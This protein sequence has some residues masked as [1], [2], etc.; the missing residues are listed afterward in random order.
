MGHARPRRRPAAHEA[1]KR[2]RARR[3]R[4][5]AVRPR[6]CSTIRC[7]GC[8]GLERRPR[9]RRAARPTRDP[10]AQRRRA[11]S[12]RPRGVHR[13]ADQAGA[14]LAPVRR[15]SPRRWPA[16]RA[17]APEPRVPSAAPAPARGA[18]ILLAEDNPINQA[19]AL[20]ILEPP[21]LPRRRRRQRR[22]RRSTRCAASTYAAVLMD[23]QMP[24]LDGYA[25]TAEIR[26]P[27]GRRAAHA[28][29]RHDRERDAGRPRAL[30]RRGMDDYL[31]KPLD[32]AALDAVL[33]RWVG[34]TEATV[35]DR[36]VL[37]ALARDVGDEAIVDEICD[38]F[39]TETGPRLD[40]IERAA[41]GPRRR[42]C[43]ASAP[44]RSRA[45]PPMLARSRS[46]AR[47]P[48][49]SGWREAGELGD[50]RRRCCG[51]PTRWN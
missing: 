51:W 17:G 15:R 26:A 20:D 21:R 11:T 14:R 44:T 32:G 6:R 30:P 29:H 38:L 3:G 50:C 33:Q 25:A 4:R 16:R 8:D 47:R 27:R 1:L 31:S 19:V 43:C 12:R 9:D 48:S 45:R 18:S 5:A 35:M 2:I 46:R 36:A 22:S 40:E 7:P 49:S 23:C 28:D 10:A 37:R 42:R 39:L 41:R 13:D 24:V 34:T